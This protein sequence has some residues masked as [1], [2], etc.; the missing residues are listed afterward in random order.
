MRKTT[1][2]VVAAIFL[3]TAGTARAQGWEV[4]FL[5]GWTAPSIEEELVYDPDIDL[6]N[7]PGGNVQQEGV[8]RLNA[9]GSFAFGGSV[10]YFF[11]RH[12]AIEGRLDTID[13]D[14]DTVGP[15]FEA[16]FQV[17][18]GLGAEAVLDFGMGTIEVERLLPLSL[19]L[20]A[21]SGGTARVFGSGG[22]SYLPRVRF[23]AFQPV[24]FGVGGFG[25]P[26]IELA[27]VVLEAGALDSGEDRLGFN[28]GGGVEIDVS[29]SVAIVGD[30]RIH[31]F[32]SQTFVW[33]SAGGTFSPIEEILLEELEELPPI[34][35][36]LIYF[37]ATG[38]V[39]FRF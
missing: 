29:P 17:I 5:G 4:S 16:A 8:F 20:K 36:E 37:Q 19:N 12:V 30:F 32:P 9:K 10:A 18:P 22:L 15:R 39:A 33:R 31:R 6:P 35:V 34:E 23:D 3:S 25:I 2:L 27:S 13:F 7:V 24:S 26:T 38:G 1:A 14:I 11:N 28:A 21:Q